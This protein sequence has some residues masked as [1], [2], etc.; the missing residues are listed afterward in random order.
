[1]I[2]AT[3]VTLDALPLTP[4]GKV[5]RKAL[6][7]PTD[8]RTALGE[9]FVSPRNPT[10][11]IIANIMAEILTLEKV[12]VHDNF[13]ERGGHSLL[14]IRFMFRINPTLTATSAAFLRAPVANA[15]G[16]GLGKMATSGVSIF[17]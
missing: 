14:A 16:C 8:S 12:G 2:P 10:E 11:Q 6:P 15:L 7:K 3:F 4:N 5:N 1:M 9:S 13:F 17:A